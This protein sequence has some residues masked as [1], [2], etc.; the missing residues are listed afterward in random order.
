M[1]GPQLSRGLGVAGPQHSPVLLQVEQHE[2]LVSPTPSHVPHPCGTRTRRGTPGPTPLLPPQT[3]ILVTTTIQVLP[4]IAHSPKPGL[5]IASSKNLLP[6]PSFH[7]PRD[8]SKQFHMAGIT[9]DQFQEPL[10]FTLDSPVW[11]SHSHHMAKV[12]FDPSVKV[13]PLFTLPRIRG[14]GRHRTL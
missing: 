8:T 13:G 10:K 12:S 14:G 11:R 7:K 6:H 9:Y 2:G 5:R 3:T 4:L 1:K